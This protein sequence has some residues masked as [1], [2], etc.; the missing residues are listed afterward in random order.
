M[1]Y[2]CSG[3]LRV[4]A[5]FLCLAAPVSAQSDPS[6]DEA[7]ISL[8]GKNDEATVRL[9]GNPT[10]EAKPPESSPP[11]QPSQYVPSAEQ[12]LNDPSASVAV[13]APTAPAVQPTQ[14]LPTPE[15]VLNN[16][17]PLV[18][19]SFVAPGGEVGFANTTALDRVLWRAG[20]VN[21]DKYGV[22]SGYTNINA[23]LPVSIESDRSL[24]WANPRVNIADNGRGAASVGFGR[25]IYVPGDDRV[26]GASFWWDYDG[27]GFGNYHALGGSFESIGRYFSLRGNF[28]L[29]VGQTTTLVGRRMVMVPGPVLP[30]AD[31]TIDPGLRPSVRFDGSS[32]VLDEFQINERIY[33]EFDVEV[34]TPLPLLG[35]YGFDLGLGVYYLGA[36]QTSDTVGVSVRTQAQITED[37]WINTVYTNDDVFNSQFSI[38]LEMTIP[39]APPSQWFRRKNVASYLTESAIRNYR[40][41]MALLRERQATLLRS[42]KTGDALSVAH[43][44]PNVFLPGDGTIDTPFNSVLDY[45]SLTAAER[46]EFDLIFVRRREDDTD[47]NLNTT[48]TLLANQALLGDGRVFDDVGNLI[49]GTEH[50][51]ETTYG[52]LGTFEFVLPGQTLGE[53]PLLTNSNAPGANVV[54]LSH[55]N[56]VA[57]FNIQASDPVTSIPT[58]D[59]IYGN[60]IDSFNIHH[61]VISGVLDGID[62]TSDTTLVAGGA[63]DNQGFIQ[64]N[65]ITGVP[66]TPN[67]DPG[68]RILHEAGNLSLSV[69]RNEVSDFSDPGDAG[70]EI[71]ATG[72]HIF[73]ND[74]GAEFAILE[75]TMDRNG[76]GLRMIAQTGAQIDAVIQQNVATRST[77]PNGAGFQI[78]AD[79]ATINLNSFANNTATGEVLTDADGTVIGL[80]RAAGDGAVLTARMGGTLIVDDGIDATAAISG[81]TLTLNGGDGMR[82]ESDAATVRVDQIFNNI[83]GE[84]V[85]TDPN[86][87]PIAIDLRNRGNGDDGLHIAALNA[88]SVQWD[89]PIVANTFDG[90]GSAV[91]GNGYP[92]V[93]EVG[94]GPGNGLELSTETA[95]T[96]TGSSIGDAETPFSNTFNENFGD[97]ISALLNAGSITID[98]IYNNQA[99]LNGVDNMGD[100]NPANDV[101]VNPDGD[102]ISIVNNLGGQFTV[103]GVPEH[104]AIENNDFSNNARAGM[105]I[106]GTGAGP[107]LARADANLGAVVNNNFNRDLHGVEGILFDTLDVFT[108]M[109]LRSNTFLGGVRVRDPGP[110]AVLEL[111]GRGIGGLIDGTV[112]DPTTGTPA[113]VP[114][115]GLDLSLIAEEPGEENIFF[116]LDPATG[117]P[118]LTNIDAHIGLIFD[119]N[120]NNVVQIS[121]HDLSFALDDDNPNT[122]AFDPTTP[123]FTGEG[124]NLQVRDRA[125][126]RGFIEQSNVSNNFGHGIALEVNGTSFS[127][128]ATID[129]YVIGGL[130]QGQG[131]TILNNGFNGIAVRRS[132]LGLVDAMEMTIARNIIDGNGSNGT[133][134]LDTNGILLQ[135]SGG[136][137]LDH[138]L[139][140][141][142]QIT[143]NVFNGIHMFVEADAGIEAV[144]TW[145]LID[146]NG[147]HGIMTTENVLDASDRRGILGPWT[148]NTIT[149]NS[150]SGISLNAASGFG[151]PLDPFNRIPLMIGTS[152]DPAS[153]LPLDPTE[154]NVITDNG[155][156]GIEMNG[157]GTAAIAN[158]FIARNGINETD[159]TGGIDLNSV[160]HAEIQVVNNTITENFGDGLELEGNE[161]LGIVADIYDNEISYNQ[162][163]GFDVISQ[164]DTPVLFSLTEITFNNNIV[165]SNDG[166]GVYIVYTT[167]LT[168]DQTVQQ[169]NAFA[170]NA[171]FAQD[172]NLFA[173]PRLI[174][175]SD[176]N[177]ILGNGTGVAPGAR[178][179]GTG[180]VVYVGTSD[181]G[182]G[183]TNP[184]GF[185]SDGAWSAQSANSSNFDRSGIIMSITNTMMSGNNGDDLFFRSFT[186][187]VDPAVTAGNWDPMAMPVFNPM[188][189]QGDPLAR[190]DLIFENNQ[191][192]ASDPVDIGA[193]YNTAEPTFKSRLDTNMAG[194]DDGP[195]NNAGRERNAQRQ[196]ARYLLPPQ[197]G[198]DFG[199]FLF[200]GM[201]DSTFRVNGNLTELFTNNFILDDFPPIDPSPMESEFDAN[202]IFRPFVGNDRAFREKMPYGWG[203]FGVLGP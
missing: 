73:A 49:R 105:F 187:T 180:F 91:V 124:V 145:N 142:N 24:W 4:L 160:G 131:N 108:T 13:Q 86:G 66:A 140:R 40:I 152:V 1:K 192:L 89:Q 50:T 179:L 80:N 181:G 21:H 38:N 190:L 27:G 135:A 141:D 56:E 157:S 74:P 121:A 36:E 120:T 158:N 20:R 168:H 114:A 199:S 147:L 130:N 117:Q 110:P 34:A 54:T 35:D 195:Y 162:G 119:G 88:G 191:I 57:G 23:F 53:L 186:S 194:T 169:T 65:Q 47:T 81:N 116:Q 185:A 63:H 12:V 122:L 94:A 106:G 184:G 31:P 133:N 203:T 8:S 71:I 72:G 134:L 7:V 48:I 100:T 68:V 42:P 11:I 30:G 46:D 148:R 45:M 104:A 156:D 90:N 93:D 22:Y 5:T 107:A 2:V 16:P 123:L 44:D 25:R 144:T 197:P 17:P 183:F 87:G 19:D 26:Y 58:A 143:N 32:L 150:G 173:D 132:S 115:G 103:T 75:N 39:D 182:Y 99:T 95:G 136:F 128:A 43:I 62:I 129:D 137:S 113:V 77:D 171:G 41:P 82:I 112:A 166:E 176:G 3:W 83:F 170:A 200:A 151:T 55:W 111:S 118:T 14:Y 153:G 18:G 69:V 51:F 78:L 161:S 188:G 85:E 202:G 175:L 198:V 15:Q 127:E 64:D 155:L 98:G 67:I 92:K 79:A 196:A 70:I 138:Y 177:Q 125:S 146:G 109:K 163:R 154:A 28:K 102:G 6:D 167:S 164:P 61:N 126:L 201:G 59:G 189:Y 37:F 52:G 165:N 97:G 9:G 149:N 178:G 96:I 193:F 101:I 76:T 139:I 159:G 29:P 84:V 33:Q 10:A 60:G 172:G 174:F